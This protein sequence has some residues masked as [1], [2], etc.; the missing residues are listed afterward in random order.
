MSIPDVLK[1]LD[2]TVAVNLVVPTF[3]TVVRYRYESEGK[4]TGGKLSCGKQS[5]VV[6][7]VNN[8]Q[9]LCKYLLSVSCMSASEPFKLHPHK[10]VGKD[11]HWCG[12][13]FVE[14]DGSP[15]YKVK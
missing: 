15:D 2:S 14:L 13:L 3:D 6:I 5:P 9:P 10:L 12:S 7:Q 4:E 11:L 1:L 8:C